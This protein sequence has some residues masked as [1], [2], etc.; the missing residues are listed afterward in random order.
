LRASVIGEARTAEELGRTFP[1]VRV[2]TSSGAKRVAEIPAKPALVVA[3]PGAE[4]TV[5]GGYAAVVVLDTWLARGPGGLR[6][7]EEAVRRWSNALGLAG[8]GAEAIV[9]GDPS[10]PALQALVRWDQPG[11]AQREAA[12]R[13][14]AH[15]PPAAS[16]VTIVGDVGAVDEFLTVASWPE[17]V[18]VYGPVQDGEEWR[19]VVRAPRAQRDALCA[20]LREVMRVRSARKLEAVKVR[21][22]PLDL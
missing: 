7:D 2:V 5:A 21:V 20:A 16:V 14:E 22:D 19:A 12:Q 9:V 18:E 10:D 3:T 13:A 6:A 17:A 1:Q 8:L 4:P 11:F 15:L